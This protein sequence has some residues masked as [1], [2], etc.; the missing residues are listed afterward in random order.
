MYKKIPDTNISSILTR[1]T[2]SDEA[3]ALLTPNLSPVQALKLLADNQLLN[4]QVQFIAHAIP[5]MDAIRWALACLALR[6][7]DWTED[8]S[9]AL[10]ITRQWLTQPDETTRV[11]AEVIAKRIGLEAAPA[12]LAQSVFWSGSGSIVAP[13]LPAV[14]PPPFL[15]AHAVAAAI[16]V[17]AAIPQWDNYKDFYQQAI[18]LGLTIAGAGQ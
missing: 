14:M 1:Y 5:M 15:Y 6:Q 3:K 4:D 16:T 10:E 8:E 18:H 17:A 7:A 13:D 9:M 2:L 12:W 11:R